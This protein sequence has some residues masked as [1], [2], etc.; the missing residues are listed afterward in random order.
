[1]P[2]DLR[3]GEGGVRKLAIGLSIIALI[4][5]ATIYAYK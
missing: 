1:M 2:P 4:L 5:Y 3:K